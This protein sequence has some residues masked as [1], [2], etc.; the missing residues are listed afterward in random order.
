MRNQPIIYYTISGVMIAIGILMLTD[1]FSLT[2]A[3]MNVINIG[4]ALITLS[5]ALVGVFTFKKINKVIIGFNAFNFF[6]GIII[7]FF[8]FLIRGFKEDIDLIVFF[9]NI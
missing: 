5:T 3:Q 4:A 6:I 8:G 7:I 9:E 2:T 1:I